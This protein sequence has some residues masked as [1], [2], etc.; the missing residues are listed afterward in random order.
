MFTSGLS[1]CISPTAVTFNREFLTF[2]VE[3]SKRISICLIDCPHSLLFVFIA[4]LAQKLKD[5]FKLLF[6]VFKYDYQIIRIE[7][8]FNGNSFMRDSVM[9]REHGHLFN[10]GVI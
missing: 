2:Q 1:P 6:I 10:L 3:F 4:T 5:F 8:M 9:I 7:I